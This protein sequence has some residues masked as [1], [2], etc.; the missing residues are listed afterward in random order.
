MAQRQQ[1][2]LIF[3]PRVK[4]HLQAIAAKHHSHIRE[5]IQQ[6]LRFDPE[7]ETRNRKPL[8]QPAALGATWEIR[9]GPKNC[10]RV[11][12]VVDSDQCVVEVLA[13]GV[14]A[15]NRLRIGDEE[16]KL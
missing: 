11:L 13:I 5:T 3:D 14:K 10:F 8:E 16:V 6:Q 15:G 4:E 7:V 1:Y 9:F 2:S 12:Y